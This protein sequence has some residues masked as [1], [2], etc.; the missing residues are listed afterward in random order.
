VTE[1]VTRR[2][3]SHALS[4]EGVGRRFGAVVARWFDRRRPGFAAGFSEKRQSPA[5]D[6]A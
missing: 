6:A 4:L 3:A 2:L 1:A 5:E